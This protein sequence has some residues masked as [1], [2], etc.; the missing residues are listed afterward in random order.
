MAVLLF[1]SMLALFFL[2]MPVAFAITAACLIYLLGAPYLPITIA[3]HTLAGSLDSFLLLAV[4]MFIITAKLA[5]TGETTKRIFNF[6]RSLVGFIPG[7]LGHVNVVNSIIFAGMTGSAVADTAGPGMME[8]EAM[9]D[10]GFDRP[11]ACAVTVASSTVGPIIPPSVPAVIY[12]SIAGASV[13]ALFVAGIIPGVLMG[14]AMMAVVY[15][16]AVRRNY[17]RDSRRATLAEVWA[18][19]KQAFFALMTPVILLGSIYSGICTPTEAAVIAAVY[20]LIIEM[21]VY[22]DL[23]L[24]QLPRILADTAIQLGSIMIVVGAA[25]ILSW[26]MGRE[27]IPDLFAAAVLGISQNRIFFLSALL[28][29]LLIL[30]CFMEGVSVMIILLPILLPLA[31]ALGINL[32]HFGIIMCLGVTLGV[33]T[34]PFGMCL[35]VVTG[36]TGE[37]MAAISKELIP[38]LIILMI[39][40]VMVT[41][42]PQLS[43]F[44]PNLLIR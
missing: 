38:F 27:G 3:A 21:F 13:G 16:V 20:I 31:N 43:L 17:P 35:F 15:W 42:I 39:V 7:G 28:V 23:T 44:L 40:L 12:A 2:H 10:Q 41:F 25:Y 8:T 24:G 22:K 19:F 32:V 30:G 29:V 9:I 5:N 37:S 6:A 18:S 34:P 4:P 14:L 1:A 36:C 26:I 11:F 33:I